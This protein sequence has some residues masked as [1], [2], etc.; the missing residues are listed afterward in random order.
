M[1]DYSLGVE[2][3]GDSS[4]LNKAAQDAENAIEELEQ[5]AEKTHAI[6]AKTIDIII[7][8]PAPKLSGPP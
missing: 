4:K 8:G 7:A 5:S 2:I 3:T 6:A 1:P